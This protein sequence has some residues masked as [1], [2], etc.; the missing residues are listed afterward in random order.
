MLCLFRDVP[1]DLEGL[2]TELVV[3]D[4]IDLPR[5]LDLCSLRNSSDDSGP[6]ESSK[7]CHKDALPMYCPKLVAVFVRK[8]QEL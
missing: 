6:T 5:T 3:N 1:L 8:D 2:G 4:N 7:I